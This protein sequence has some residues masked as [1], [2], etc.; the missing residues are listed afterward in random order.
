MAREQEKLNR[1]H[2]LEIERRLRE[3]ELLKTFAE[4]QITAQKE[5][6][7]KFREQLDKQCVSRRNNLILFEV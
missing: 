5:K 3:K 2:K 6:A 4:L 1:G 7:N